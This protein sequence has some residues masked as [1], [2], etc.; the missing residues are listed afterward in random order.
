MALGALDTMGRSALGRWYHKVPKL[1]GGSYTLAE[2]HLRASLKAN[3]H[4]TVSHLFLVEL[5]IDAGRKDEAH[6]E[7]LKVIDSPLDAEWAPEDLEF[8]ARA[9]S[10]LVRVKP[11]S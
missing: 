7:L 3:P 9:R 8:K 1:F 10:L 5:V 4:S 2:E 6:V 11:A